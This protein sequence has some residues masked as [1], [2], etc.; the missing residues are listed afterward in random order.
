MILGLNDQQILIVH[1]LDLKQNWIFFM[2]VIWR[3]RGKK[4]T[5]EVIICCEST[6]CYAC[7]SNPTFDHQS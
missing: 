5:I 3:W 6:I 2:K 1:K 4:M 7:F